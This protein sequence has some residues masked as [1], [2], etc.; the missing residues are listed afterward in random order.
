MPRR[1]KFRAV[2]RLVAASALYWLSRLPKESNILRAVSEPALVV[3]GP[4][5]YWTSFFPSKPDARVTKS[6]ITPAWLD[7]KEGAAG[8]LPT[9]AVAAATSRPRR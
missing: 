7:E 4:L 3:A 1:R 8:A 9:Q 6:S 2:Q 5:R